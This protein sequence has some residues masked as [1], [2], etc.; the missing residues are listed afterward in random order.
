MS[1]TVSSAAAMAVV[2]PGMLCTTATETNA[3][4]L[5]QGAGREC[6]AMH[7]WWH[8]A[9]ASVPLPW[10]VVVSVIEPHTR[11]DMD[12]VL[13]FLMRNMNRCGGE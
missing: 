13:M 9:A 12:A 5:C 7:A 4:L 2:G 6:A 11:H 10:I 3:M 8:A 1:A